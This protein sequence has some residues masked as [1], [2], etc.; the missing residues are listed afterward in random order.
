MADVRTT[1]PQKQGV[2]VSMV[3]AIG[4][5]SGLLSSQTPFEASAPGRNSTNAASTLV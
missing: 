5:F 2:I 3:L 4:L 1:I